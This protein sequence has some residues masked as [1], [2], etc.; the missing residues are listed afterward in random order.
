MNNEFS[1]GKGSSSLGEKGSFLEEQCIALGKG[2]SFLG[3]NHVSNHFAITI[4]SC[5]F[6]YMLAYHWKGLEEGYKFVVGSIS[7]KIHMKKLRSHKIFNT[8]IP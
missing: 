8:F 2:A 4:I 5:L 7:I 1:L 6:S 3:N